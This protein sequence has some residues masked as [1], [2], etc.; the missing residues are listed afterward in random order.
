MGIVVW[1][2]SPAKNRAQ[3]RKEMKSR[4]PGK[5]MQKRVF[6]VWNEFCLDWLCVARLTSLFS[7]LDLVVTTS[8]SV[9]EVWGSRL[10]PV[11]LDTVHSIARNSSPRLFSS[12]FE[13]VLLGRSAAETGPVT[14]YTLWR[15]TASIMKT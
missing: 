12:N 15:N 14:H 5:A 13:A 6:T 3:P 4:C 10:G 1:G 11:K 7:L 2:Q 8:T 9:R